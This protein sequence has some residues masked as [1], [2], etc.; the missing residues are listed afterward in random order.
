M[1]KTDDVF[2]KIKD[3]C[4]NNFKKNVDFFIVDFHGE[5][6]SEKM[7]MGHFLDGVS[8]CVIGTHT[9][10]LLPIREF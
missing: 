10:C 9:M 1:K 8:T 7:A 4:K 6:T 2:N 3:I 5:I